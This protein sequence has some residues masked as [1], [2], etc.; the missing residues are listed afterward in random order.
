MSYSFQHSGGS[1]PITLTLEEESV[2]RPCPTCARVED[3]GTVTVRVG[4]DRS[5][6]SIPA[7]CTRGHLVMVTYTRSD[8]SSGSA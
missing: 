3:E 4:T 6:G 5:S 8:G 7:S 1:L 2:T